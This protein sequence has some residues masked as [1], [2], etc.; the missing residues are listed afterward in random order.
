MIKTQQLAAISCVIRHYT[1]I[2][3]TTVYC[4]VIQYS[5]VQCDAMLCTTDHQN[6][7]QH[8]EVQDSGV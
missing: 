3:C 6:T 1:V 8:S 2:F 5:A 4:D 7:A